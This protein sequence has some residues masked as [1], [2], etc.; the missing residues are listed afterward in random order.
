MYTATLIASPQ[1]RNL[2]AALAESLRNAWGGGD[3][4]WMA[5][6]EAAEFAV[7]TLPDNQWDVWEAARRCCWRT[8]TAP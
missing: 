4:L 6:D 7:D 5:P 8:W 2:E 1:N 3:L